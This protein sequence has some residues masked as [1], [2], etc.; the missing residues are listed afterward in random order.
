MYHEMMV[1][2][3]FDGL[4]GQHRTPP[5]GVIIALRGSSYLIWVMLQVP[6]RVP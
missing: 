6:G 5:F 1:E 2:L 4:V 3:F